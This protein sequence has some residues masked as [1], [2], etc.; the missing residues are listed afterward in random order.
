VA[1]ALAA[2]LV[3]AIAFTHR[4]GVVHGGWSPRRPPDRASVP[5]RC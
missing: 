4:Q 5:S 2:Q 1:R 3:L